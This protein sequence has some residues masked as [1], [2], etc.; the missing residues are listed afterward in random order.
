MRRDTVL[1]VALV[2]V[3]LWHGPGLMSAAWGNVGMLALRDGLVAQANVAPG[4]YPVYAA[5][6]DAPVA[7]RAIQS[8]HL[9]MALDENN[10]HVRW[11]LGRLALALGDAKTAT[12]ALEPL[13]GEVEHNPVLYHD[14]LVAL[15]HGGRSREVIGLYESVPPPQCTQVISDVVALADLDLVTGKQRQGEGETGGQ[16]GEGIG[17]QEDVRHWLAQAH[18]LRPGDLYINYG[19]W[20]QAREAGD[21]EV[22]AV[23][24]EM[25]IHFPLEAVHPADER[26][27]DYVA[28]TV[29][30]L[31]E[32]GLWDRDKTLN[33]VSF[34]VWQHSGAAG[35]ERLLERLSGR[36][37]TEPDWPFYLAELYHRQQVLDQAEA[38]YRQVLEVDRDYAQAWLRIGMLSEARAEEWTGDPCCAMSSATG[39]PMDGPADLPLACLQKAVAWYNRYHVLAPDDL[40]GLNRLA[41]VCA[42]LE[43]AGVEDESC[44]QAAER[45]LEG[46]GSEETAGRR[47]GGIHNSPAVVLQATLATYTDGRHIVAAMLGVPVESVKLGPNSVANGGFEEW[48]RGRPWQWLWSAMFNSDPFNA[49]AFA[50]GADRLL[51]FEGE[52]SARV[53]GFWV[54]QEVGRSLARAGFWQWDEKR[55]ALRSIA[56]TAGAPYIISFYYRTTRIPDSKATVWISDDAA[57]LWAHDYGLPATGETW[58]HFVALGWNRSGTGATIYPLVRSF[59]P[60]YVEFDDVQVRPIWLLEETSVVS[61]ETQFWVSGKGN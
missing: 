36:Y 29:P 11:A 48:V 5:L 8:L 4:A 52:Q 23:Y 16:G 50:K 34:L 6:A 60:G 59:A 9:A 10:L 38:M 39:R 13:M 47:K 1:V 26:L 18:V 56:L 27:L 44:R 46:L 40:L 42:T 43:K 22:A 32:E 51:F 53:D 2:L 28:D 21:I 19:L 54:Q 15:S 20:K 45:V 58:R 49:A 41:E 55:L 61:S 30:C 57:V 3:L 25:L 35:V 37:P 7:A 12:E 14:V 31:L 17:G 33:V 24:S